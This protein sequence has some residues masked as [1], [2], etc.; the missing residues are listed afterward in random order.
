MAIVL[1]HKAFQQRHHPFMLNWCAARAAWCRATARVLKMV[2][3]LPADN[4]GASNFMGICLT[5]KRAGSNYAA[6]GFGLDRKVF[7]AAVVLASSV[8]VCGRTQRTGCRG[9]AFLDS[10]VRCF[11]RGSVP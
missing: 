5:C 8:L 11:E 3:S 6:A 9:L 2:V 7:S 10:C 1:K 4:L